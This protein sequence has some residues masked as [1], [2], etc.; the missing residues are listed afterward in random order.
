M[1]CKTVALVAILAFSF[2]LVIES[3]SGNAWTLPKNPDNIT[4][5]PQIIEN[6]TNVEKNEMNNTKELLRTLT[7]LPKIKVNNP[8]GQKNQEN[9]TERFSSESI[10][11]HLKK[12]NLSI[13]SSRDISY[14]F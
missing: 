12:K 4:E 1:P 13:R 11:L 10:S 5:L 8:E 9:Y 14:L 2:N 6:T 7:E 3:S